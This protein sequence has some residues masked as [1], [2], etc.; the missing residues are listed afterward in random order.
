MLA[1]IFGSKILIF[2]KMFGNLGYLELLDASKGPLSFTKINHQEPCPQKTPWR[3]LWRHLKDRILL[4]KLETSKLIQSFLETSKQH[5]WNGI[6]N[7]LQS[8]TKHVLLDSLEDISETPRRRNPSKQVKDFKL[9]KELPGDKQTTFKTWNSQLTTTA[10]HHQ[11][12]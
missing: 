1:E 4:S 9:D 2:D 7:W 12:K 10:P 6:H 11:T 3:T 5:L 8:G